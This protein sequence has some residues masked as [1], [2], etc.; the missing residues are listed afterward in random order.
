M[1]R[2]PRH[3][4]VAFIVFVLLP[5]HL[6]ADETGVRKIP[7][8]RGIWFTLGQFFDYGDK[9]SGGLGTYTAKHIPLAIYAP[10]V[11]KTFFVYGG[12]TES[13][14]RHLLAMISYFDHDKKVVPQPVVVHDKGGVDDPHDNPSLCIDGDGYLWVF[15]SG[16]ARKRPGYIYKSL[17]PFDINGFEQVAE[18]EF[19]YPQPWWIEG[20]GFFFCFTKYTRGRELYWSTSKD[21]KTWSPDRKL[22]SGGHYQVTCAQDG[23]LV[24]AFNA[25]PRDWYVDG[26]TNLYFLQSRDFGGSW[27]AITGKQV[28]TPVD[29]FDNPGLVRDYRSEG[30]NVYMKD[31]N[32]D[33][34]GNPIILYITS[35]SHKPGPP[36]GLRIWEVAHWTGT[37][38][39]FRRITVAS[40][41]YDMGSL[42]VEGDV[43][44]VVAPTEAGPQGFGAGGEMAMWECLDGKVWR[45]IKRLTRNS[46]FNHTYAR[47]PVNAHPEFYAFWADGNPNS[48]SAS[49]IY[50]TNKE[51]DRVW[52]LPYNMQS[53]FS[54]PEIIWPKEVGID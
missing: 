51:G 42:Y 17:R 6:R 14:E 49:H 9:Y 32:F 34:N 10:Q 2:F 12:T 7:G 21:G 43:W 33:G 11:N 20:K 54:S 28:A 27:E 38:W 31:I 30:R 19:A 22:A 29:S 47:R 53:E 1:R 48:M 39:D 25:H 5:H 3:L 18:R 40:H 8:Y 15:V 35:D 26:R 44:R 52:R 46:E 50:F 4:L 41:N 24:T 37:E 36:G 16:R 45:R 13:G 23:R